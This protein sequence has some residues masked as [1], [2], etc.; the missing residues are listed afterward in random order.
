MKLKKIGIF[1][2][3][4]IFMLQAVLFT[5][6]AENVL[7]PPVE[8]PIEATLRIAV[9][10]E[11]T[12]IPLVCQLIIYNRST[13]YANRITTDYLGHFEIKLAE[14]T[15]DFA[16]SRGSEYEIQYIRDYIVYQTGK[17]R[18]SDIK[19]KRLYS[20]ADNNWYAGDLHQHSSYSDGLNT[21]D[22]ILLSNIASGLSWGVL[23]DHNTTYGLT[24][25]SM[26]N[27][28]PI[29]QNETFLSLSGW[30]VTTTQRG[31]Y[32]AVNSNQVVNAVASSG[33]EIMRII[34]DINKQPD[35]LL[36]LNHPG[37][38]DDMGF[39]DWNIIT[40]ENKRFDA[41]EVWNG[42]AAPHYIGGSNKAS[43][44]K[45]IELLNRQVFIP[46]TGGSDNHKA[47]GDP[48]LFNNPNLADWQK[49]GDYNG[50]PR[51]YVNLNVR[52]TESVL[53]AVKAGNSFVTNG[54]MIFADIN[55]KS[56]G[57][58]AQASDGLKLNYKLQSN[59]KIISMRIIKNGIVVNTIEINNLTN[60]GSIVLDGVAGDYYLFELFGEN[61]GYAVTN[62]IFV[63]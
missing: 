59:E 2:L 12:L 54:P 40:K 15:Y 28:M 16:F 58:T 41:F 7:P 62:P 14:G 57:Q 50:M 5:A 48:Y 53:A 29:S 37:R 22:E 1:L 63:I 19:L 46:M 24:E 20:P 61:A 13:G 49:R 51:L 27:Y 38:S 18:L 32:L 39:K 34:S 60:D 43:Y 44:D 47:N 30:E 36:Q 11:Q 33:P 3:I 26:G 17:F 31:H 10:D 45:W 52:N 25:W 23:S 8:P 35:V 21:V 9:V 55:G 6:C 42:K 56:Y 4:A